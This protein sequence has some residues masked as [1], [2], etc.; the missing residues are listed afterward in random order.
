MRR[1]VGQGGRE[2]SDSGP[3]AERPGIDRT[4]PQM[5]ELSP[6][7][8]DQ[9]RAAVA[10]RSLIAERHRGAF[11]ELRR[12][13]RTEEALA[14]AIKMTALYRQI[15][16]V[17]RPPHGR[18]QLAHS[19]L[20]VHECLFHLHRRAGLLEASKEAANITAELAEGDFAGFSGDFGVALA[21]L[22]VDLNLLGHHQEALTVAAGFIKHWYRMD[23]AG[24]QPRRDR[25]ACALSN[26][27]EMLEALGRHDEALIA[28]TE[29]VAIQREVAEANPGGS[30]FS[31]AAA[32]GS[33]SGRLASAGRA[34]EAVD[35]IAEA[36]VLWRV[37]AAGRGLGE[38]E[39]VARA[40]AN[41]SAYLDG[42]GRHG[43]AL[44]AITE[45]V[46]IFRELAEVQPE[47]SCEGLAAWLTNQGKY[48]GAL[49][50]HEDAIGPL[51]EALALF[52]RLSPIGNNW[53][54]V[55][56]LRILGAELDHLGRGREADE[57]RARAQALSP[58]VPG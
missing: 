53:H 8:M 45:A 22:Y 19:L 30:R 17:C 14:E 55:L 29:A 10:E 41:Q 38:R 39:T 24:L 9:V 51:T 16:G 36:I 31:L 23:R 20:S 35:T 18:I 13:G 42:L 21:A 49:G 50:R 47:Q 43:E 34:Q 7:Q 57:A 3:S 48:L 33:L 28:A 4:A 6:Q 15:T 40:L 32:L 1:R 26:E 52:G 2:G 54:L 12:Q 5:I 56:P 58:G 37:L 11:V 27:S 46:G 25:L 44:V